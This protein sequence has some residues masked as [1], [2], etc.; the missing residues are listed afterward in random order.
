M[1]NEQAH[2]HYGWLAH[3]EDFFTEW[4]D[5]VGRRL[6]SLNPSESN[7]ESIRADLSRQVYEEMTSKKDNFQL[8]E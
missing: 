3:H 5:E 4:R 2:E 1:T 7:R 6:M 8:G